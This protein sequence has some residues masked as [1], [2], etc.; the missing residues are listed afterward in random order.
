MPPSDEEEGY[1]AAQ[2]EYTEDE[3]KQQ[4]LSAIWLTDKYSSSLSLSA[5]RKPGRPKGS[6]NKKSRQNEEPDE[7]APPRRLGR[8]PGTGH[9]QCARAVGTAP[10][11][12]PKRPV[13]RPRIHA[14]P[15]PV[16]VNLGRVSDILQQL[17]TNRMLANLPREPATKPRKIR[18]RRKCGIATCKGKR[19]WTDCRVVNVAVPL[20]RGRCVPKRLNPTRDSMNMNNLRTVAEKARHEREEPGARASQQR[21]CAHQSSARAHRKT[22]VHYPN[23]SNLVSS[24]A[25]PASASA[26]QYVAICV[27]TEVHTVLHTC[28]RTTDA[29]CPP[30]ATCARR[31]ATCAATHRA[32]QIAWPRIARRAAHAISYLKRDDG[33]T[34]QRHILIQIPSGSR[35]AVSVG[36]PDATSVGVAGMD[37]RVFP[38]SHCTDYN[39]VHKSASES[40]MCKGE[41]GIGKSGLSPAIENG[42]RHG[43]GSGGR[44]GDNIDLLSRLWEVVGLCSSPDRRK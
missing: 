43:G 12:E 26:N 5:K 37:E 25:V 2:S 1:W 19:G 23:P 10:P 6:R 14:P 15:K 32:S 28:P 30:H 18:T 22:D 34:P 13:G 7:Q 31:T 38:C 35:S 9:L 36:N 44:H 29:G 8:P 11:E 42:G 27:R 33:P 39:L 3:M 4:M 21:R 16:T 17:A 20:S 40:A 41:Q 24:A